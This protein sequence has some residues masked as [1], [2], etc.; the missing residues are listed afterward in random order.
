MM[1]S[2]RRCRGDHGSTSQAQSSP[3]VARSPHHAGTSSVPRCRYSVARDAMSVSEMVAIDS[4]LSPDRAAASP[5]RAV[6]PCPA[7]PTPAP[8]GPG[9]LAHRVR[10]AAI[11]R[12]T[13][14]HLSRISEEVSKPQKVHPDFECPARLIISISPDAP[15]RQDLVSKVP[16]ASGHAGR[17]TH[18]RIKVDP[19]VWL[20]TDRAAYISMRTLW[21]RVKHLL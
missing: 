12:E 14:L 13:A 15:V 9:F 6:Q 17:M 2:T 3:Q 5:S 20:V 11:W 19:L 18:L 16:A 7:R 21:G 10:D 8:Q 1:R 4:P